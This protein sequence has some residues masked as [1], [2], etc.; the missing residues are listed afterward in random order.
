LP[1]VALQLCQNSV[2]ALENQRVAG[3]NGPFTVE[4]RSNARYDYIFH[5]DSDM[6]F[7]GGSQSWI[8]EAKRLMESP[9]EGDGV[10]SVPRAP[11]YRWETAL[12]GP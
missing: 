9:P 12:S 5:I 8:A 4:D 2:T 10:Q 1:V 6:M 7:G 11:N 3:R